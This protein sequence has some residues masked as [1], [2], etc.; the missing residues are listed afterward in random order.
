MVGERTTEGWEIRLAP[1]GFG[2]FVPAAFLGVWLCFWAI[3]ESFVFWFLFKGARAL[4]TGTPPDPGRA[5]IEPGPALL[6]GA[7][8]LV[9]LTLWTV[10]GLAA[11]GEFLRLLWSEDRL[12]AHAAGLT[13]VRSR[14]PFRW[15]REVARERI[16][17][18]RL[19][20]RGAQLGA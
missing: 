12:I 18:V 9:W 11:I 15:R 6:M 17:D 3:G 8:L 7:F 2:R 5:P 1:K 19:L 14:G 16:R 4:L 20:H 10:G 13:I